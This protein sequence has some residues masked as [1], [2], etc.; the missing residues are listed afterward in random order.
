MTA[1]GRRRT[2]VAWLLLGAWGLGIALVVQRS[3]FRERSA[4]LAEAAL[5]LG[6]STTYFLVEQGGRQIGYAS[7]QI[8]TTATGF[9]VTDQLTAELT[10]AG[11]TVPA[12]AR[13][14]LTLSRGFALRTFDVAMESPAAPLRARGMTEGDSAV[15]LVLEVPGQPADSQRIA[16][17]GPILLPAVIPAAAMLVRAPKV[18]RRIA[19]A[20]LDPTT[21]TPSTIEPPPASFICAIAACAAKN[22]W[23]RF[24]AM[25]SSQ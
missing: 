3:Y 16:V 17:A 11:Q 15:R 2:L 23:R 21:M 7:T 19:L 22:W 10:V 24:T 18:G 4:V 9:Q 1:R 13:A 25:R 6:P 5:R 20:S 14:V 8:D 12:S